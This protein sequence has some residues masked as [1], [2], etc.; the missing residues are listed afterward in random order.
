M[1]ETLVARSRRQYVPPSAIARVY[2]ALGEVDTAVTWLEKAFAERSNAI[3][4]IADPWTA[5]MRDNPRFQA[6]LARA[7]LR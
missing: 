4:Y 1:L 6:I 2:A 7:G 5:G 3:A